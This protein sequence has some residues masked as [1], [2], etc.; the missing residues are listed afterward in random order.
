[1][2]LLILS[3]VHSNVDSLEAIIRKEKDSDL[4]YCAGDLVDVGFYPQEV[5]DCI[6]E[7]KI[8]SVKGNHDELVIQTFRSGKHL[9][10]L[11]DDQL[12]WPIVNARKLKESSI[13]YLETL[14]KQIDFQFDEVSYSL[15]HLYKG[16]ETIGSLQEFMVF[17]INKPK[18]I[19]PRRG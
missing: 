3:D 9:E 18:K 8:I 4:I 15:Q 19:A 10:D 7:N 14:P 17:G 2:K 6:R 11:P 1:M 16:Y 13:A 5:I 12:T